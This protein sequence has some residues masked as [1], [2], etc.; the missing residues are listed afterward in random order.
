MRQTAYTRWTIPGQA[1]VAWQV[2]SF[3]DTLDDLQV[4]LQGLAPFATTG[5]LCG[6]LMQ[7]GETLQQD[8]VWS[9]TINR[10]LQGLLAVTHAT[11]GESL[12][13]T[14]QCQSPTCGQLMDLPLQLR[15]FARSEDPRQVDLHLSDGTQVGLRVPTGEDQRTWLQTRTTTNRMVEDLLSRPWD[16][17]TAT[18]TRDAAD[19]LLAESDPL[20]TLEIETHCPECGASNLVPVDLEQQCLC[21]L[22]VWQSRLLDQV[23]HLALAYHWTEAEILAIPASRRRLYLDRVME[24]WQ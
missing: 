15:A 3:A 11:C 9:W 4:D 7:E 16:S 2:R 23:H 6:C 10:R 18:E 20:T 21:S 17:Q 5:I 1:N 13:L 24:V 12:V 14:A 8:E 22:V 19:A